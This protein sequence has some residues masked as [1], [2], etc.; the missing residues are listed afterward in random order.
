MKFKEWLKANEEMTST[1]CIAGVP[2]MLGGSPMQTRQFPDTFNYN[3]SQRK[4]RRRLY[5][6]PQVQD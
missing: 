2:K 1:S 5:L 6:L 4:R 3:Q